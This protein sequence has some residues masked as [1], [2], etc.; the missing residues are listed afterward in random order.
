MK[1]HIIK[2]FTLFGLTILSVFLVGKLP[3]TRAAGTVDVTFQADKAEVKQND[4]ITYTFDVTNNTGA[5]INNVVGLITPDNANTTYV[6][7]SGQLIKPSKT[8]AIPDAWVTDR[9]NMGAMTSG[10]ENKIVFQLKVD[11][12]TAIGYQIKTIGEIDPEGQAGIVKQ[13]VSTVVTAQDKA[14]FDTGDLFQ[15]VNNTLNETN[16]RDQVNASMGNV[17]QFKFHIVNKGPDYSRNTTVHVQI[18]WDT[19][20][21]QNKLTSTA[22]VDADNAEPFSDSQTVTVGNGSTYMWPYDGHYMINGV[23]DLY[24]CPNG[25]VLPKNFLWDP[26]NI[27]RIQ[28]GGVVE[29]FFKASV[30]GIQ[31]PT[32]TPTKSVTPTPTPTHTPTPTMTPTVTPTGTPGATPTPTPTTSVT[33]TPT[34]TPTNTPGPTPTPTPSN[35]T[36]NE[37]GGTCGSNDNC[38]SGLFCYQGF[39]RN[40]NIV[41]NGQYVCSTN[42]TPTPTPVPSVLGAVAPVAPKTGSPLAELTLGLLGT[43]TLGF[44]LRRLARRFW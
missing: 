41:V 24:N 28:P 36:P 9:V 11:G 3:S 22:T 8:I 1:K 13:A 16:W 5:T 4:N 20:K 39:C 33:P 26:M 40:P 44:S 23:T 30:V 18:P 7:N 27:G 43:G 14:V 21:L 19:G 25:C 6:P 17:I 38:Q 10:Q 12:D 34:P 15:A 2:L 32:P 37:C 31:T 29:V 35:G 42:T